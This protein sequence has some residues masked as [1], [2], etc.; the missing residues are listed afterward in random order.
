MDPVVMQLMQ[1]VGTFINFRVLF[2]FFLRRP[3]ECGVDCVASA[4]FEATAAE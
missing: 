1:E 3:P 4:T 2:S